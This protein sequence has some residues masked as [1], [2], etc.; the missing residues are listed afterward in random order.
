MRTPLT[1]AK[2]S[3]RPVIF[4]GMI[5]FEYLKSL[6]DRLHARGKIIMANEAPK[7]WCWVAPLCD[8]LG[9]E[10]GWIKKGKW[11]PFSRDEMILRRMQCGAKPYCIIQNVDYVAFAPYVKRYMERCLAYGFMPGFF[12]P[13]SAADDS[14]YFA[15][16]EFYERDRPH[17]KKYIPLCRLLSEAGWRPVNTLLPAAANNDVSAEQFGNRYVALFNHSVTKSMTVKIPRELQELVTESSV[18]E[19]LILEPET[20]RVLDFA[21]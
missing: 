9:Q 4:K 2:D 1:Y 3:F 20:C 16:P 7:N 14:H 6:S 18:K 8:V 5:G 15:H 10:A 11:T 12:S 19:T 21:Q 17:F 13:K